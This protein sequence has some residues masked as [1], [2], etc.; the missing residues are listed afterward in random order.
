LKRGLWLRTYLPNP[1]N[2][3][4]QLRGK[5][6][7]TRNQ[8]ADLVGRLF[9]LCEAMEKWGITPGNGGAAWIVEAAEDHSAEALR[10]PA[11]H[12][13]KPA[14]RGG[15]GDGARARAGVGYASEGSARKTKGNRGTVALKKSELYSS[16]WSMCDELRGGM[17]ASQY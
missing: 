5:L 15:D 13:S 10:H 3:I 2:V 11:L 6:G 12:P 7:L 9:R 1:M 4:K 16:L 14:A 8:L 17:V